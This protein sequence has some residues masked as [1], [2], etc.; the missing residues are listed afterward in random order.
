MGREQTPLPR[1]L[2]S[3]RGGGRSWGAGGVRG[4][5][6]GGLRADG[7]VG[8]GGCVWGLL[9]LDR[10]PVL[11]PQ[12]SDDRGSLQP[13][14][15]LLS[16][17]SGPRGRAG[18]RPTAAPGAPLVRAPLLWPVGQSISERSCFCPAGERGG[19]G[20]ASFPRGAPPELPRG[21]PPA[22]AH[23]VRTAAAALRAFRASATSSAVRYE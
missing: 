21:R 9:S 6:T 10:V 11:V 19:K 12:G 1:A 16:C 4:P 7:G 13:R 18:G 5:G 15:T 3:R 14:A 8:R 22:A 23:P 20:P 17:P 2:R